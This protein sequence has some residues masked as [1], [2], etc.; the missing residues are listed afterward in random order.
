[1]SKH[2]VKIL[3]TDPK[4]ALLKLALPV[5]LANGIQ[6]LY[7]FVDAFWIS[8]LKESSH[9]LSGVGLAM[10]FAF[11]L[12]AIANGIGV[13]TNSLISRKI[14]AKDKISADNSATV[15]FF[16]SLVISILLSITLLILA[17]PLFNTIS[18]AKAAEN[19]TKYGQI[20]FIGAPLLFI[21]VLLSSILRAE[22]DMKRSMIALILGSVFNMILD[23]LFMFIFGLGIRGAALATVTSRAITIL[24][25]CFWIFKRKTTYVKPSLHKVNLN[26]QISLN[27]LKVGIPASMSML[28]M[29]L[30]VFLFNTLIQKVYGPEGVS[31]YITGSRIGTL[32][33][34]PALGI[35]AAVI[36][37]TGAWFGAQ[38]KDMIKRTI[39]HAFK[40]GTLMELLIGIFIFLFSKV[41]GSIFVHDPSMEPLLPEIS[42]YLKITAIGYPFMPISM[43][44]AGAFNGIG[45]SHLALILT[46]FRILIVAYP[47]SLF[48]SII[49]HFGLA[50][51]WLGILSGTLLAALF[52]IFLL[53]I[54]GLI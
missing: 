48:F 8:I 47:F 35:Q 38:K 4:K 13:G 25:L 46:L 40:I 34:L 20:I 9:A 43:F 7:N 26:L 22:G 36:T 10:P 44:S 6:S 1:M 50:G 23:P 41:I 52:G 11:G 14:G 16:L 12:I 21:S 3:F 51:I 19:A 17:K 2:S 54:K 42:R 27:I 39:L 33:V 30:G 31:V 5:I 18:Q 53:K 15:G 45:K 49:L 32:A 24:P 37:L 29:S 28:F